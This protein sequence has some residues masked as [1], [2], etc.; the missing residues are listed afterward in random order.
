MPLKV[1]V[2]KKP[3]MCKGNAKQ[4]LLK[5]KKQFY[6]DVV[7]ITVQNVVVKLKKKSKFQIY[8]KIK[9]QRENLE[10]QCN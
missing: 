4:F 6:D 1:N 7:N 10:F 5:Q 2:L 3:K 8:F 9:L